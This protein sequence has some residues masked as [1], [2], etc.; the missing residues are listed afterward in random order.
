M[1]NLSLSTGQD[2]W[3]PQL[4]A[5]IFSE[6]FYK[7]SRENI[8]KYNDTPSHMP[9]KQTGNTGLF[10]D[11]TDVKHVIH[12][13]HRWKDM[14]T[15]GVERLISDGWKFFG[16]YIDFFFL[17]LIGCFPQTLPKTT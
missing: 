11:R 17:F 3:H 9:Q 1:I 10:L 7:I 6:K 14:V 15:Y 16:L 12:D 4:I 13:M 8:L 2:N 5:Q